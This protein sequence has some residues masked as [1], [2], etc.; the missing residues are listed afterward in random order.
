M[1]RIAIVSTHPIQYNAP[2]F[3]AL[4]ERNQIDLKVFYTWSQVREKVE[5]SGFGMSIRWDIPF[6]EGYSYEFVLNRAKYPGNRSFWGIKNPN[7]IKKIEEFQPDAVLVYGWNFHSHLKVMR[8]FKKKIPVW[9]RGDSHLLDEHGDFKK[10]LRRFFLKW[11]YRYVDKAFY[12][13]THNKEY[14]LKHGLR[15]SQLV[16]GPHAI[17]NGRFF[18]SEV[19]QYEQKAREW[20]RELGYDEKDHVIL[21]AGKFETKKNPVL[22]I[23]AIQKINSSTHHPIKLL[24]VGNGV[25]EEELKELAAND[26]NIQLLPFQNQS[27]MPIVYRL[28]NVFCLPSQGPGETWGLAINEAMACHRP[29]IASDKVGAAI[30]MIKPAENGFVFKSNDTNGLK[31]KIMLILKDEKA[32]KKMSTKASL[33]SKEFDY[34]L[35][36]QAIESQFA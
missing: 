2:F 23:R 24:L 20:R 4:L 11:V 26:K 1:K 7:L 32:L 33:V 22:L 12:V 18:D 31:D 10:V 3:R 35:F 6:L 28:G 36:C 21:F 8:Y 16:Y 15:E 5:D 34:S 29:V 9:F 14:F 30:D 19:S 17:E 13:G 25:L 27:K